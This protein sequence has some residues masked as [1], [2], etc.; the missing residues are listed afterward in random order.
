MFIKAYVYCGDPVLDKSVG[1][2][3]FRREHK[4]DS[5]AYVGLVAFFVCKT[6]SRI[7]IGIEYVRPFV[8][9][10]RIISAVDTVAKT[11]CNE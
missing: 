7:C 3:F 1:Y 10:K 9:E 4:L 11:E 6:V 8:F 5:A 2:V